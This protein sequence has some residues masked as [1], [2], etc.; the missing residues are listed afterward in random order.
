MEYNTAPRVQPDGGK[1]SIAIST[2]GNVKIDYDVPEDTFYANLKKTISIE[3][4]DL[5]T[6]SITITPVEE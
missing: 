3:N 2:Y 5:K 4:S 6:T 1:N